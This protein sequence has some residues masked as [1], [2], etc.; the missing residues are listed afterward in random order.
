MAGAI[1]AHSLLLGGPGFPCVH[2]AIFHVMVSE[3][4]SL[5]SLP[6]QDLPAAE[7][8][9]RNAGT[10]DDCEMIEK[11]YFYVQ[12]SANDGGYCKF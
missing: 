10:T 12:L 6:P 1:I 8:I 4:L 2:P 3:D 5:G 9:P 7:D 11:V